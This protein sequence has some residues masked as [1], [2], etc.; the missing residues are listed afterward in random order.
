[1]VRPRP[2]LER[3]LSLGSTAEFVD[4][5]SDRC[6]Q[7]GMGRHLSRG[8]NRGS[9][10]SG[11]SRVPHKLPGAFSCVSSDPDVRTTVKERQ[12]YNLHPVGQCD[13]SDIHQQEGRN[14]ITL[15]V[16]ASQKGV[17]LV[18]GE[19]HIPRGRSHPREGE[20]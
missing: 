3:S 2:L 11:G 18:H 15:P 4:S 8:E 9:V 6:F 7:D 12:S 1:M 14:A 20:H 10:D 17:E 13:C 16:P 5:D 19:R